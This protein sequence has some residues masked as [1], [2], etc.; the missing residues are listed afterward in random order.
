VG[1]FDKLSKFTY[2]PQAIGVII[3]RDDA[4]HQ[5]GGVIKE[6]EK[7]TDQQVALSIPNDYPLAIETINRGCTIY[8]IQ[9]KSSIAKKMESFIK[10]LTAEFKTPSKQNA[11]SPE[12][13]EE[14]SPK[15]G[16]F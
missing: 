11:E 15:K 5:M 3:N 6:F 4:K 12:S 8:D 13:R 1:S 9:P 10:K 2:N 7:S 16:F 14:R